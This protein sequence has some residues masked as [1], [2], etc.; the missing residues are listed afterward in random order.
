MLHTQCVLEL[1]RHWQILQS[2][3]ICLH[4][5][6]HSPF[7]TW[8]FSNVSHFFSPQHQ[9][10]LRS[11]AESQT[12]KICTRPHWCTRLWRYFQACQWSSGRWRKHRLKS[13][14]LEIWTRLHNV[15]G[16]N[17][18][19]AWQWSS[20][21]WAQAQKPIDRNQTS[22]VYSCPTETWSLPIVIW[23]LNWAPKMTNLAIGHLAV[24]LS[25]LKPLP[26]EIWTNPHGVLGSNSNQAKAWFDHEVFGNLPACSKPGVLH[27]RKI[28]SHTKPPMRT[29]KLWQICIR[30]QKKWKR[31][32][33]QTKIQTKQTNM[34]RT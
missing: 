25:R 28:E 11:R 21:R 32:N 33:R 7:S 5:L 27:G 34:E 10:A 14:S 24:A 6:T 15:P 12:V 17:S 9:T 29:L 20:G 4:S 22:W 30:Q 13:L 23:P 18:N 2:W 19:Q 26:M 16:S 8:H 1:F 31:W 3:R